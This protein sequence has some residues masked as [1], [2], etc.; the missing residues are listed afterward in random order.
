MAEVAGEGE[1]LQKDLGKDHRRTDVEHH[2]VPKRRHEPGQCLEIAEA[3]GT[4]G[5]AVGAR[6]HVVDVRSDGDVHGHG[7]AEAHRAREHRAVFVGIV[8]LE[9]LAPD[10]LAHAETEVG[11]A[12]DR[13]VELLR[14]LT[15]HAEAPVVERAL[16]VFAGAPDQRQLEVVN[17][18]GTVHEEP[19]RETA[20]EEI[21]DDRS[22]PHLDEVRAE[23]P[24]DRPPAGVGLRRRGDGGAQVGGPENRGES[25]EE[26]REARSRTVRGRFVA[27]LHLAVTT[28]RAHRA[29]LR[30]I[31]AGRTA[32][33]VAAV[34][35]KSSDSISSHSTW[36]TAMWDSWIRAVTS[37]GTRT[38][39]STRD[40]S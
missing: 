28:P 18:A 31:D 29:D 11:S 12:R 33:H 39:T 27:D 13:A 4:E 1:R 25:G 8:A 36:Q 20:I 15:R 10:R 14:G 24:Q 2:A 6:M 30:A 34:S 38:A 19:R 32:T 23:A 37:E 26:V 17:A 16:D 3:G 35:G 21:D 22:E 9:D 7:N 5:G 40:A